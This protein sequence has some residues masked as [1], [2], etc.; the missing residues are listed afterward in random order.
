VRV[1]ERWRDR[2]ETIA[3]FGLPTGGGKA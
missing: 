2:L 3:D 1:S